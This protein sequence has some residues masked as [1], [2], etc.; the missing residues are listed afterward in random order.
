MPKLEGE[1]IASI[2]PVFFSTRD[3]NTRGPFC[4]IVFTTRIDRVTISTEQNARQKLHLFLR[5]SCTAY[6]VK[7][8]V[9]FKH[10]LD[11]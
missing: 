7:S 11:P 8:R 5:M 2:S 10:P 3:K 9:Y 1:I 6:F 4:T